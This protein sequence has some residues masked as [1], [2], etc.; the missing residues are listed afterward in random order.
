MLPYLLT[1]ALAIGGWGS[2]CGPV[3]PA[4]LP[5]LIA[6]A[7]RPAYEWR[8][9][10]DDPGRH[11]LYL[12]GVQVAG[13]DE[14]TDAYRTYDA[15]RDLW[16]PVTAPP[17]QRK[18]DLLREP[19]VMREKLHEFQGYRLNGQP[20]APA[21]GL[22]SIKGGTVPNDA[23]R[24]FLVMVGAKEACD[25]LESDFASSPALAPYRDKFRLQTYPPGF[26]QL[27]RFDREGRPLY[28][29]GLCIVATDGQ[30]LHRQASYAGPEQLAEALRQADPTYNPANTPDLTRPVIPGL[31]NVDVNVLMVLSLGAVLAYVLWPRGAQL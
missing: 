7:P 13:W 9:R 17:W 4:A 14:R 3:G 5:Y 28:P 21:V 18:V 8:Q 11:Y 12:R 2:G 25:R 6:Q 29:D 16:G 10:P 20:V 27:A 1:T 19:G 23:G 22:R 31:P 30:E 24:P 15:A 26:D